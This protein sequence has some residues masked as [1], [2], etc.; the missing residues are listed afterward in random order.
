MT[1]MRSLLR[2]SLLTVLLVGV[3]AV[4]VFAATTT[5]Q[6]IALQRAGLDDEIL[7]ALIQSDGSVFYLTADDILELHRQGLSNRVI[8]AM[9]ETAK[10]VQ[11]RAEEA[12]RPDGGMPP[13][14]TP[15][16]RTEA[17]GV[18]NV[19]QQVSQNVEAPPHHEERVVTVPIAVPVYVRAPERTAPEPPVYWGWGGQRRPDSWVAAPI[20]DKP[21][22][23]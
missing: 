16:V 9:Q 11:R 14:A 7:I 23:R 18:V 17:P 8:R 1:M 2:A 22:D 19:Y 15:A 5:E 21:R 4:P 12:A 10:G 13:A 3:S 6:L 20:K